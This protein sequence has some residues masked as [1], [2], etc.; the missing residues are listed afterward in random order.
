M[1][2]VET[3]MP[4]LTPTH[5]S[6]LRALM[7]RIIPP[8]D[9]PGAW[10]AGVG[11]YLARQ[12]ERGLSDQVD[13]YRRG[14]EALETEAQAAAGATFASLDAPAQAEILGRL[15]TGQ[16]RTAWPVDPSGFF[17]LVI[18]HV[19]EGYYSDPGNGGNREAAAWRMIG[20]T[21]GL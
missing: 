7:D 3:T 16:V 17:S 1:S 20:F 18:A 4:T 11:D 14:L 13:E 2:A 10:E 19:M 5:W 12:F 6:T 21:G 9:F 8:D 15:E